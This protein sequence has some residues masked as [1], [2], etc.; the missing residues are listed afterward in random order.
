MCFHPKNPALIMTG[1]EDGLVCVSNLRVAKAEDAVLRVF[2]SE[3]SVAEVGWFGPEDQFV[4]CTTHTETLSLFHAQTGD[5]LA[6]FPT[7]RESGQKQ[8][9]RRACPTSIRLRPRSHPRSPLR[10]PPHTLR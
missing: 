10:P 7:V 6:H 9:R 5:R 1:G 4:F 2:N 8:V 3:S